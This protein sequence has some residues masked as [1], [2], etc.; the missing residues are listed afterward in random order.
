MSEQNLPAGLNVGDERP[1]R[2]LALELVRVTEGTGPDADVAVDPIDGTIRVIESEHRLSK[3][4]AHCAIDYDNA[5]S[6]A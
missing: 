2:N 6:K 5:R 1:D 3:I 4:R